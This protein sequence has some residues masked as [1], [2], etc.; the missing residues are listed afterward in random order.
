MIPL[1]LNSKHVTKVIGL[2]Q[3]QTEDDVRME[4]FLEYAGRFNYKEINFIFLTFI[5][6]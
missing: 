5:E 6:V 2:I 3:R 4:L 1:N